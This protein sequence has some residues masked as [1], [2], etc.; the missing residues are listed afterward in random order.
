GSRPVAPV[1]SRDAPTRQRNAAPLNFHNRYGARPIINTAYET[2]VTPGTT[3][4]PYLLLDPL[5]SNDLPSRDQL[6]KIVRAILER[7][8]GLPQTYVQI[9][10]DSIKDDPI[11]LREPRHVKRKVPEKAEVRAAGEPRIALVLNDD[12]TIHHVQERGYVEAPVRIRSI[13]AELTASGLFERVQT[14]RFSDR[15]I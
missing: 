9:V 12:H 13:M 15:H 8:Y 4:P 1:T 5:G 14:K 10:V 7:K 11:R 2:P 3:D 6:Q